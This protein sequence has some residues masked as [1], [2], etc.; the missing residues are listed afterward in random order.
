MT[1]LSIFSSYL[2]KKQKTQNSSESVCRTPG[3]LIDTYLKIRIIISSKSKKNMLPTSSFYPQKRCARYFNVRLMMIIVTFHLYNSLN[4]ATLNWTSPRTSTTL[5]LHLQS[6]MT[7]LVIVKR[8][9]KL[10]AKLCCCLNYETLWNP[11]M[12]YFSYTPHRP[13]PPFSLWLSHR[14][15]LIYLKQVERLVI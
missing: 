6:L 5:W 9:S 10:L 14:T 13:P 8:S 1:D 7:A 2:K 12:N 15:C 3:K 11:F 4:W